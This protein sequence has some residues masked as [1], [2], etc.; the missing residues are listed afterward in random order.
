[1]KFKVFL[2]TVV[3]L[4]SVISPNTSSASEIDNEHESGLEL[5][6][7]HEI[8][9]EKEFDEIEVLFNELDAQAGLDP[10]QIT[11]F[12]FTL[13]LPVYFAKIVDLAEG[14]TQMTVKANTIEGKGTTKGLKLTTVTSATTALK[15]FTTGA[16][17]HGDKKTAIAKFT[18]TS[19]TSMNRASGLNDYANVT[20]HTATHQGVLYDARTANRAVDLN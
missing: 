2:F 10:D 17:K 9:M 3:I 18:S 7:N 11:P 1:M 20:I 13:P 15:N 8:D 14:E 19:T 5:T 12:N 16:E 4:A 6:E